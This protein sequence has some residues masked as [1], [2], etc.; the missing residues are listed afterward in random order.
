MKRDGNQ[1]QNTLKTPAKKYCAKKVV[2]AQYSYYPGIA[3]DLIGLQ[4]I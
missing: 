1:P 2:K 3:Q 4:I